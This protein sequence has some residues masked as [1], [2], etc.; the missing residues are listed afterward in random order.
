M[1]KLPSSSMCIRLSPCAAA[2][3][4]VGCLSPRAGMDSSTNV[5]LTGESGS[6]GLSEPVMSTSMGGIMTTT[7]E[8][9]EESSGGAAAA[10]TADETTSTSGEETTSEPIP[11]GCGN[12]VLEGMEE[13]D[14]G[15]A[16]AD[17]GACTSACKQAKCGDG[18]VQAGVETCDDGADNGAYNHCADDCMGDGPRCGDGEI[19]ADEG[20]KCDDPTGP[21]TGCLKECT[22]AKSCLAIHQSWSEEAVSGSYKI[23]P[24][25]DVALTVHC[26]MDTDGGGYTF[27]KVANSEIVPAVTAEQVCGALGLRLIVPRSAGHLAA[28][29]AVASDPSIASIGDGP[30]A[31]AAK[32]LNIFG[33]YPKKVGESCVGEA[34]KSTTCE[35]WWAGNPDASEPYFVSEMPIAGQPSTDQCEMCS[36]SYSWSMDLQLIGYTAFSNGD[37]GATSR[38]FLCDYG[39]MQPPVI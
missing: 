2:L 18:H 39:D 12:G 27:V 23:Y 6:S 25:G 29:A 30:Q 8:P 38:H 36:M 34:L 10:S 1:S 33:I 20:E 24:K 14:A 17:D 4:V 35:E 11:E 3:L 26:D 13:C 32:Y 5:E 15:E 37:S 21:A 7:E 9:D 19:Q 31:T 22:R 28:M 16:N